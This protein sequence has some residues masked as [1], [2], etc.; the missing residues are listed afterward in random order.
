MK[1]VTKVVAARN[2]YIATHMPKPFGGIN[3][4]GMHIH[5]SL[6]NKDVTD[7]LFYSEDAKNG[8]LSDLAE[9]TS[10]GNSATDAKCAP[11]SI[12]GQTVSNA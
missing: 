6:W 7:N 9:T 3:G 5:Q 11:S 1:M 10:A 12:H 4:S 2:G 8:Y